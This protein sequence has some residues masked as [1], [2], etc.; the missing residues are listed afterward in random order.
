MQIPFLLFLRLSNYSNIQMVDSFKTIING[1]GQI[2]TNRVN[3]F[4]KQWKLIK[5]YKFLFLISCFICLGAVFLINRYTKPV[6]LV[7]TKISVSENR[8]NT[9]RLLLQ[10]Q[11]QSAVDAGS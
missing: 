6:Y 7:S 2:Q 4:Q 3:N 11:D 9:S 1:N 5:D 8:N 10:T